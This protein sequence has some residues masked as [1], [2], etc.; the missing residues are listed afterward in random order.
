MIAL[1][2]FS[3]GK[4]LKRV[5]KRAASRSIVCTRG[6]WSGMRG[7]ELRLER[8]ASP[9]GQSRIF[10]AAAELLASQGFCEAVCADG[11]AI[12]EEL[13][14]RGIAPPPIDRIDGIC[15]AETALAAA[16]ALGAASVG[17]Y[18]HRV[19]RELRR[20]VE[21]VSE[22]VRDIAVLL[23]RGGELYSRELMYDR[24]LSVATGKGA[25]RAA[26]LKILFDPPDFPVGGGTAVGRLSSPEVGLDVA[27]VLR[28]ALPRQFYGN[29][30][31]PL[32]LAS[33]AVKQ[34]ALRPGEVGISQLRFTNS[35]DFFAAHHY[36]AIW[37]PKK[38]YL[39]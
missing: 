9:A 31:P 14:A 36:N 4:I 10:D 32:R 24:G 3:D 23:E 13:E 37:N 5:S 27:E 2:N 30:Y 12:G 25:F 35:I 29:E 1:V 16:E 39:K 21:A 6:V 8:A 17:V 33:A 7:V 38:A 26:R 28:Y 11:T 22:R 34:G 20:T 15:A 18:A 19:T